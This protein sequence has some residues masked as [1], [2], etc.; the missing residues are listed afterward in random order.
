MVSIP[1]ALHGR[2]ERGHPVFEFRAL[3]N[4][5]VGHGDLRQRMNRPE[6]RADRGAGPHEQRLRLEDR[7]P[8]LAAQVL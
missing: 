7:L 1:P 8:D 5:L 6:L 4:T 2:L 3:D